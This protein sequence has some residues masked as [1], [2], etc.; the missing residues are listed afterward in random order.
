[1]TAIS[2]VWTKAVQKPVEFIPAKFRMPLAGA[3]TVAVFLV[4]SFAS[5]ETPGNSRADRAISL[6]GL[7]V[8]IFAFWA[9]SRN[10]KMIQWQTVIVGMLAQYILALFVLRT[11]AGVSIYT[12]YCTTHTYSENLV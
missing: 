6:F 7:V 2:F 4:G 10:R 12:P 9:T 8:F 1:M 11:K 5:D 3:G